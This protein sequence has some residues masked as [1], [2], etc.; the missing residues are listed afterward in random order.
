[1]RGG[2]NALLE[3]EKNVINHLVMAI[4]VNKYATRPVQRTKIAQ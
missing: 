3:R 1:M 2:L 4:H